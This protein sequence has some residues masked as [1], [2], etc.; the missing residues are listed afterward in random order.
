M[1]MRPEIQITAAIKALED[2]V[3]PAIPAE[4]GLAAEQSRLVVGML[5]LMARQLP[6]QF[7]FDRDEL[8]RLIGCGDEMLAAFDTVPDLRAAAASLRAARAEAASVLAGCRIGPDA[9]HDAA[10]ALNLAVA[11]AVDMAATVQA[12]GLFDK[13]QAAVT[14]QAKGQL[15]RD[16]ALM[17]P[18]GWEPDPAALPTIDEL[19]VAGVSR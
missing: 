4:H 17:A 15:L 12:P 13:V 14:A 19:L 16:R 1:Q 8:A 5:R 9:L 2:V 11:R 7:A 18:Q 3:I 10:R 6:L